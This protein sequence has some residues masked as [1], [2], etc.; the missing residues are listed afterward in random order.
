MNS[1]TY[2]GMA[3]EQLKR[4]LE[5]VGEVA[6]DESIPNGII[7]LRRKGKPPKQTDL[8]EFLDHLRPRH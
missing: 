1:D 4:L 7:E 2:N 3:P 5:A 6:I 8:Q